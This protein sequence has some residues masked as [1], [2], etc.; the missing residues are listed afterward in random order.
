EPRPIRARPAPHRSRPPAAHEHPEDPR[1]RPPARRPGPANQRRPSPADRSTQRRGL[2]MMK[3]ACEI[4][5]RA[6]RPWLDADERNARRIVD[7]VCSKAVA[8][9]IGYFRFLFDAV[10]GPLR[11]SREEETTGDVDWA[12]V[13][14][15]DGREAEPARA[16]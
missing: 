7:M 3:T 10:D 5:M 9:H 12:L 4:L 16:A 8:G 14:T 6:L 2:A 1:R 13:A 11:P 15:E